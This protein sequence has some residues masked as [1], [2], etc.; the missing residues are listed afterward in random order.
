MFLR[1]SGPALGFRQDYHGTIGSCGRKDFTDAD[2]V[3]AE[4]AGNFGG[5]AQEGPSNSSRITHSISL[6]RFSA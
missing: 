2:N 1:Q 5:A 4:V 6:T 3:M